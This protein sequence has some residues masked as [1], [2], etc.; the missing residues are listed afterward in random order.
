MAEPKTVTYDNILQ[1]VEDEAEQSN[2]PFD[3]NDWKFI[4]ARVTNQVNGVDC[5]FCV[6]KYGLL[7]IQDLPLDLKVCI[8]NH[9]KFC[10]IKYC[11]I[12]T[13]C[14]FYL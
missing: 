4:R 14:S 5:G 8:F 11:H 9:Y 1:Y 13:L 3:R 6:I 12:N 10:L 2:T 7:V